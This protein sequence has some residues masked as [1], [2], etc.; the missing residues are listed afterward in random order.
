MSTVTESVLSDI[1]NVKTSEIFVCYKLIAI[2]EYM[3]LVNKLK[4][5]E[6]YVLIVKLS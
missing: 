2:R 4:W 5:A 1:Y 6:L 3:S